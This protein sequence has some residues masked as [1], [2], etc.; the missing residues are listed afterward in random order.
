MMTHNDLALNL[1][2]HLLASSDPLM[3]WTDMQLGPS[4]S[5]RPDVYAIPKSYSKFCPVA[6]EVKVSVSDFRR[7]V[8]AGKWMTY[9]PF[10][11]GIYFAFEDGLKVMADDVPAECGIIKFNPVTGK[12][13]RARKPVL[14]PV[15]TLPHDAWVKMLIDGVDRTHK[16]WVHTATHQYMAELSVR[17]KVGDAVAEFLRDEQAARGRL[18]TINAKANYEIQMAKEESE[19]RVADAAASARRDLDRERATLR[20]GQDALAI[21]MGMPWGVDLDPADLGKRIN[22][23]ANMLEASGGFG[24]LER[25]RNSMEAANQLIADGLGVLGSCIEQQ[26]EKNHA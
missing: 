13:R 18:E 1:A 8:T 7:D 12:W 11:S 10:A 9:R 4:G 21:A 26:K 2:S 3:V 17:K 15:Q 16:T 14:R 5:P 22:A 25:A 23:L 6:Y 24:F 20:Q 19:R